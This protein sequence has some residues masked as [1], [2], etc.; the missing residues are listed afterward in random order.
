MQ[1]LRIS[2]AGWALT[3]ALGRLCM[4]AALWGKAEEFLRAGEKLRSGLGH[5]L[6]VMFYFDGEKGE[7]TEIGN[8]QVIIPQENELLDEIELIKKIVNPADF[9]KEVCLFINEAYGEIDL[10]TTQ[11]WLN[12]K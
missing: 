7:A 2:L 10:K 6:G 1:R 3:L 4:I 8:I 11:D 9:E 12:S 5:Y